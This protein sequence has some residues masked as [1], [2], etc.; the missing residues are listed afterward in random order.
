L[1][2]ISSMNGMREYG[3]LEFE[4]TSDPALNCVQLPSVRQNMANTRYSS[5]HI[6]VRIEVIYFC[7]C[8]V[9]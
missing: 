7:V 8:G 1:A 2:V 4:Y 3:Q 9:S 6:L 5:L